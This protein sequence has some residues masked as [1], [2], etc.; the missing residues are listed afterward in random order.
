MT[1]TVVNAVT[2]AAASVLLGCATVSQA[3]DE[4]ALQQPVESVD[5]LR[6]D[7]QARGHIPLIVRLNVPP[8]AIAGSSTARAAAVSAATERVLAA[9]DPGDVRLVRRYR[10]VAIIA[11]DANA[12]GIEV[13]SRLPDVE[14]LI[15]DR[16][17]FPQLERSTVQIGANQVW[18]TAT[19]AGRF[20]A[21]LDTGIDANHPFVRGRIAHEACF[22]RD[23]RCRNGRREHIGAGAAQTMSASHGMHVAGI[24]AGAGGQHGSI[25]LSGVAPG[26]G[27]IPINVFSGGSAYV[28]DTVAALEYLEELRMRNIPIAAAN[29]SIGGG[30]S[31]EACDRN[32]RER[33][34]IITRLWQMNTATV[35]AAGNSGYQNSVSYPGCISVAVTVSTL[36]RD[37]TLHTGHNR[38]ALTDILA[39]GISILSAVP[40][41]VYNGSAND[42][43]RR[44]SGT[45]MATPHIA[46][47]FALLS[48]AAPNATSAQILT[49][50]IETG[51]PVRDRI[52][53]RTFRR[54]DLVRALERLRQS[55]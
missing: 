9:V 25:R 51:Q 42:D 48:S 14:E 6:A 28:S 47:A 17:E 16:Q 8:E 19:G 46:G 24:A 7:A 15:R 50:L 33:T 3:P 39:P 55:P 31:R 11:V 37:N 54:P 41:D 53:G 43:Y 29:M 45:S 13:L 32:E 30:V 22:R 1:R 38:G 12:R 2:I 34:Q 44:K 23:G 5:A 52:T 35:I 27:I 26:A 21:I 49:A 4:A 18:P 40:D 20:V 36:R 10:S